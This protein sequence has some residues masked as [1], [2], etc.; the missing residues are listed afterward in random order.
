M[1]VLG[2][3]KGCF[4]YPREEMMNVRVLVAEDHKIVRDGLRALLKNDP[5]L[6]I[7]A[8]A[9]NGKQAVEFNKEFS[10]DI[11]IMEVS[12]PELN[13]IEATR[14]IITDS[15]GVKVLG[16]SLSSNG[17]FL[18]DM[19]R[20]GAKGYITKDCGGDELVIALHQIIEGKTYLSSNLVETVINSCIYGFHVENNGNSAVLTPRECEITHLFSDGLSTKEIALK[21]NLSDKTVDACRRHIMDKL[22]LHSMAELTKYAIKEGLTSL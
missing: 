4:F 15:P 5:E 8:E 20:A 14:Q 11:V 3:I 17:K 13:G 10:P 19:L 1:I 9:E 16:L 18:I 6:E 2:I 12:L 7:I 22:S 21:V